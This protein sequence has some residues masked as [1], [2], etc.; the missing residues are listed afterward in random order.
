MRTV[1]IVLARRRLG[2][3]YKRGE[4]PV[5]ALAARAWGVA[6]K[7]VLAEATAAR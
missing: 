4:R 2:V 3:R 7:E 1:A 5:G 6:R